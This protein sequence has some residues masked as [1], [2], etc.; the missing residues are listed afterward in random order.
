M[1]RS[2]LVFP[3]TCRNTKIPQVRV[4]RKRSCRTSV[5]LPRDEAVQPFRLLLEMAHCT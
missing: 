2:L 5:L 1:T 3:S 4:R